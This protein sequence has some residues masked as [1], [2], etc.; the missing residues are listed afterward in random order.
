MAD[1]YTYLGNIFIGRSYTMRRTYLT[2]DVVT[3][4]TIKLFG[5]TAAAGAEMSYRLNGGSWVKYQDGGAP[6]VSALTVSS[7]D[8]VEFKGASVPDA[9]NYYLFSS[10]GTS[11]T[12]T[13]NIYGNIMSL[14][15]PEYFESLTTLPTYG[16]FDNAFSSRTGLLSSKDLVIPLK[17]LVFP[18]QYTSQNITFINMFMSCTNMT[19]APSLPATTLC[20]NCYRGMFSGCTSLVSPQDILPA[21]ALQSSCYY[22]MFYN[23]TSLEKAPVLP[24]TAASSSCYEE[25]FRG[26]TSL[27]F[28][29]C[30][31]TPGYSAQYTSGWVS[32]VTTTNGVF[33]A[34]SN[35]TYWETGN[36][37]IPS[38]WVRCNSNN[39]VEV[40]LVNSGYILGEISTAF[41]IS[42]LTSNPPMVQYN[43]EM[44][45]TECTKSGDTLYCGL[46]DTSGLKDS[47]DCGFI[48]TLENDV[49]VS[50]SAMTYAHKYLTIK[51]RP[52]SSSVTLYLKQNSYNRY[53]YY[54]LNGGT[55]L[56]TTAL[57]LSA[58]DVVKMYSI[59]T[60]VKT[61]SANTTSATF[62]I[63][64][65][66]M[67]M[68][69]GQNF[70]TTTAISGDYSLSSLFSNFR[71]VDASK[72]MIP[73][74]YIKSSGCRYM[75]SGC[76]LLEEGPRELPATTIEGY[77]Y[78]NMFYGCTSLRTAPALPAT[79]L[80]SNCYYQMFYNCT[81]LATAPALPATTLAD[82]CCYEMF[83][84]CTSL[85]TAPTEL[86][87]TTLAQYCYYGMFQGCTGLTTAPTLPA[88]S[89]VTRCYCNMFYG[90]SRL[91]SITCLAT[92]GINT[93]NSTTNWVYGVASSGTF[94]KASGI[95]WPSGNNGI[96][97]GWTV[98]EA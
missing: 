49:P 46:I 96:P 23:C 94:T 66:P 29:E 76:T 18:G 35:D 95:S 72:V 59:Q 10:I 26:C 45:A 4:G 51:V 74:T 2:I 86:S 52:G 57:T 50:V 47:L 12:A 17:S 88:T 91:S 54:S 93:N 41:S 85:A 8:K 3:G 73:A 36:N 69:A 62:D 77:A 7:G 61:I 24:A 38:G 78:S 64:G 79:A 16:V 70:L 53:I 82:Y 13:Y 19:E 22:R 75:F 60:G 5:T 65:N 40:S 83:R 9:M 48:F 32:G 37:G 28:I 81:S 21:T 71:V 98:Q 31:I 27:N 55:W 43:G 25:M 34:H 11:E 90:C 68:F 97:S 30:H 87:A 63:E 33:I 15:I 84:G 6:T 92:S 67:S 80:T 14:I 56:N 20:S 39:Y 1:G 89:L 58:G 44:R 42:N